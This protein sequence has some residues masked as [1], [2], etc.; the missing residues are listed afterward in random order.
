MLRNSLLPLCL[1]IFNVHAQAQN[2]CAVRIGS[3]NYI[4]CAHTI[5]FKGQDVLTLVKTPEN[6]IKV[7]F[8]VFAQNGMKLAEIRNSVIAQ[9]IKGNYNI[10]AD[11]TSYT[12]ME[13]VTSRI[14]VHIIRHPDSKTGCVMDVWT[15]MYMPSGFYFQCT[16]ET[17]NVPMLNMMK[18]STF[19]N[20]G[21][22]IV[23]N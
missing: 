23:L 20:S 21:S 17:T 7:N 3:N 22:A 15:D 9:G 13:K 5:T 19:T 16:P 4:N 2:G 18:G 11:D 10:I 14:I 8:D 12:F 6:A 1:L